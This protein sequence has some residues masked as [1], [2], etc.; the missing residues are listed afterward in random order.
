LFFFWYFLLE[1][2]WKTL[3]TNKV[4]KILKQ[5]LFIIHF[6]II[7]FERKGKKA[8]CLIKKKVN[9]GNQTREKRKRE[10]KKKRYYSWNIKI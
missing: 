10:R 3:Q 8:K 7:L 2:T 4:G 6:A 5:L 1:T 9:S